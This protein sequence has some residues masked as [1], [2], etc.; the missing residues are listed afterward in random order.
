MDSG[1][2]ARVCR[3]IRSMARS[4]ESRARSMVPSIGSRRSM[5]RWIDIGS[6]DPNESLVSGRACVRACAASARAW[7][8]ARRVRRRR[9]CRRRRRRRRRRR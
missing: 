7:S 8:I 4:I 6:R 3:S 9:R 5:G 2:R 1:I